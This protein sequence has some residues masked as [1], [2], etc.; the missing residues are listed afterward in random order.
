[1]PYPDFFTLFYTYFLDFQNG[2][3]FEMGGNRYE[4][5]WSE[6]FKYFLPSLLFNYIVWPFR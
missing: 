4:K 3:I 6:Y 1:M 5:K 2:N